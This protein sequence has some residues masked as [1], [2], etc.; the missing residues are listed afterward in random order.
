MSSNNK[1]TY[2]TSN[3]KGANRANKL[4]M[5][6]NL[7]K[8]CIK[9]I[10]FNNKD[11]KEALAPS[12]KEVIKDLEKVKDPSAI[13]KLG[14]FPG[15]WEKHTSDWKFRVGLYLSSNPLD[16]QDNPEDR[17]GESQ[18]HLDS[19]KLGSTDVV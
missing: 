4:R 8:G 6:R 9:P 17:Y 12:E 13:G 19:T 15:I 5:K 2:L 10:A 11:A 7:K 1:K 3:L 18:R 16:S 14:M